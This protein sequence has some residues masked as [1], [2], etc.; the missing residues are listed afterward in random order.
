[1]DSAKAHP[2]RAGYRPVSPKAASE[3]V[4]AYQRMADSLWDAGTPEDSDIRR[5]GNRGFRGHAID[6]L[7]TDSQ[8]PSLAARRW[9][10]CHGLKFLPGPL[11]TSPSIRAA[12]KA[13]S[14]IGEWLGSLSSHR[15]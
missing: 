7:P 3:R 14:V 9:D 2:L 13:G 6:L 12:A 15:H 8:L 1:M 10:Q 4:I 5:G 11:D